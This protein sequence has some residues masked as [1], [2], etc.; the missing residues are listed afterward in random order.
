MK[1]RRR[2]WRNFSTK[3]A[4]MGIVRETMNPQVMEDKEGK[5]HFNKL[6]DPTLVEISDNARETG[7]NLLNNAK[8]SMIDNFCSVKWLFYKIEELK[9]KR[10]QEEGQ[11]MSNDQGYL[12]DQEDRLSKVEK[13]VQ[14][15]EFSNQNLANQVISTLNTLNENINSLGE[16]LKKIGIGK[17]K[18]DKV[19][20]DFRQTE[21]EMRQSRGSMD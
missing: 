11:R 18:Q 13:R 9:E 21:G 3:M 1:D 5:I 6:I 10:S 15:M 4:K 2:S 8:N 7:L 16:S 20:M 17:E 14:Q 12:A 19:S